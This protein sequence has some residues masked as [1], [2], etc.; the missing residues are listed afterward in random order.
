MSWISVTITPARDR[1]AVVAALFDTGAQGV[2]EAGNVLVTHF[3]D[4]TDIAR[5]REAVALA[6][7]GAILE[8]GETPHVDESSLHGSVRAHT[9]G[10]FT[11]APPWLA[12]SPDTDTIV[13]EPGMA[14]G[15]GEHP[16]TRGALRLMQQVVR[17]GHVVADLGAGSAVLGIAA[18]KLGARQVIA[19]ELDA[20][21]VTNATD[22]IA[23]NNVSGIVH[24]FTGDAGVLL[25]LLAPVDVVLANIVSSVLIPLLP[26]MYAALRV[27]GSAV[28]AG[29]LYDERK[30]MLAAIRT[31]QWKVAS[32]DRENEWWSVRIDRL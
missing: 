24:V 21:T 19:M 23:R 9:V 32:E 13:I 8:I 12:D 10:A 27:G 25:P 29:M 7:P 14:F 28:L 31:D 18:A 6:D 2:H 4:T 30:A 3:P 5:L 15:T 26:T 22:N 11:V 16:S 1:D 20:D 17:R